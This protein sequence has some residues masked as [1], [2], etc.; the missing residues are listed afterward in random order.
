[1]VSLFWFLPLILT[2]LP[3]HLPEVQTQKPR[4]YPALVVMLLPRSNSFFEKLAET[5]NI[6][7]NA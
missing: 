1:M 5:W 7:N 3:Q 2:K 4:R 6:D